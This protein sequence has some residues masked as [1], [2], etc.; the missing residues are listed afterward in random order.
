MTPL[1]SPRGCRVG[2]LWRTA[3]RASTR[4]WACVESSRVGPCTGRKELGRD[5]S[6]RA[7]RTV[8]A[9][10]TPGSCPDAQEESGPWPLE[11]KESELGEGVVADEAAAAREGALPTWAKVSVAAT[12]AVLVVLIIGGG[13]A[14]PR[15]PW[16]ANAAPA[17]AAYFSAGTA[18]VGVISCSS[19]IGMGFFSIGLV[20][21]GIVG[22]V[23]IFSVGFFS[24]GFFSIGVFS[25]GHIA[26]G[27]WACGAYSRWMHRGQVT[28]SRCHGLLRLASLLRRPPPPLMLFLPETG[29]D[30][31][32][33]NCLLFT[34]E[35]KCAIIGRS[36]A[37]LSEH[38]AGQPV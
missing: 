2:A 34:A 37:R 32:R 33:R 31:R 26:L 8:C 3:G 35:D 19:G 1:W 18:S 30:R 29:L 4:C 7:A 27:V 6:P 9:L 13:A 15:Q 14:A 16:L 36:V 5:G 22:S 12:L 25:L 11:L 20:S 23:G 21:F 28:L 24:I 38:T 17:S 10:T